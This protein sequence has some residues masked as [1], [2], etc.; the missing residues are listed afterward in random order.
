MGWLRAVPSLAV[1]DACR[2]DVGGGI[3]AEGMAEMEG[4]TH[5]EVEQP[6]AEGMQAEVE[7]DG[8]GSRRVDGSAH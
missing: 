6:Q 3:E 4:G 2:I 7:G 5:R 1:G 8:E